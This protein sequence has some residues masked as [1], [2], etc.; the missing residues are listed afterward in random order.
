MDKQARRRGQSLAEFALIG[1]LFLTLCMGAIDLGRVYFAHVALVGAVEQGARTAAL[2]PLTND[3]QVKSAVVAEPS[4]TLTL[5][6]ANVQVTPA[7]ASRRQGATATVTA[8]TNFRLVT[9][10]MSTLAGGETITLFA[11]ASMVVQ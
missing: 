3:D 11:T 9:P 4:G 8:T 7:Y 2:K 10:L 1:P 6:A 5:S